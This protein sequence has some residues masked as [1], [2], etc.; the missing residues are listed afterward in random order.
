MSVDLLRRAAK[1]MR[2]AAQGAEKQYTA[3]WHDEAS[4][5]IDRKG[6]TVADVCDDGD[7]NYLTEHIAS[8]H[9]AVALAVADWLDDEAADTEE[10]NEQTGESRPVNPY[11]LAV[12]RAY[13]GETE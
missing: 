12:A 11:A 2:T 1:Q 9:P 8:W 4:E 6:Y 10:W 7:V 3:P 5:V 13:L